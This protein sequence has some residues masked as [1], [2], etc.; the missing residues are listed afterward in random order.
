ML[1]RI[2]HYAIIETCP[3]DGR[4]FV[5]LSDTEA[6]C[7]GCRIASFCSRQSESRLSVAVPSEMGA[8]PGDRVEISLPVIMS[9]RAVAL[10]L[11]VPLAALVLAAGGAAW[12][13]CH[14]TVAVAIG[15]V[16]LVA[17]FFI[18]YALRRRIESPATWTVTK[19]IR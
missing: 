16:A 10:L 3:A 15:L 13:G 18:L 11:I 7:S 1:H 4:A 6:D 5:R 12:M 9:R 14:E 19:I 8:A 2:T 17:T